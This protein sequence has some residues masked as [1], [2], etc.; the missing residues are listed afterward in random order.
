MPA[1]AVRIKAGPQRIEAPDMSSP[2]SS[3]RAQQGLKQ[4]LYV[5]RLVPRLHDAKA[6]TDRDRA[7]VSAHFK[8]LQVASEQGQVILA[9]RTDEPLGETFGIVLFEAHSE[10]QARSFMESDPTVQEGVMVADLRPFS[11][12]LMRR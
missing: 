6:W 3:V 8:H 9:G 11:L 5:L 4:Y 7:C 2:E 12:A 10:A 1:S